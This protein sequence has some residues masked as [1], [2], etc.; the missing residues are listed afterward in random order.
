[1]NRKIL[2]RSAW[3]RWGTGG[4][5]ATC[6][7]CNTS[8]RLDKNHTITDDGEVS[9]SLGCPIK[10]CSYHEFVTLEG[11]PGEVEPTEEKVGT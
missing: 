1:M 3:R 5:L 10:A 4:V 6:P 2:P 11:W 7:D 9:A 8:L